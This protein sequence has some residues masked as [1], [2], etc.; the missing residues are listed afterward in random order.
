MLHHQRD[1]CPLGIVLATVVVV[2]L[3][4]QKLITYQGHI[5]PAPVCNLLAGDKRLYYQLAS[6]LITIPQCSVPGPH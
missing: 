1:S 5:T 4:G 6:I 2:V 3:W